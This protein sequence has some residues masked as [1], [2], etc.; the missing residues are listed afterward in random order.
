MRLISIGCALSF[1]VSFSLNAQWT[2]VDIGTTVDVNC[3]QYLNSSTIILGTNNDLIRS[4]D[5]G[6]TWVS[7]PILDI[8][9]NTLLHDV[10]NDV[11]FVNSTTGILVGIHL[12]ANEEVILRTTDGGVSWS[13]VNLFLGGAYPRYLNEVHFMN[14]STGVAVGT[15]GRILRTIDGGQTWSAV[16]SY[17]TRELHSVHFFS[18][19]NGIIVGD[20][21]ILTTTNAGSTWSLQNHPGKYL[22]SVRTLSSSL[23]YTCGNGIYKSTTNGASWTLMDDIDN[24]RDVHITNADSAY[25][26]YDGLLKTNNAGIYWGPQGSAPA[27]IYNDIDFLNTTSGYAVGENGLVVRTTTGG[28][29]LPQLDAGVQSIEY[30]DITV[31]DGVFPIRARVRNFG[32]AALTSATIHWSVDGVEQPAYP[33]T[34]VLTTQQL[35]EYIELGSIPIGIDP[36]NIVAWT[37]S[38]NGGVD[39]FTENDSATITEAS[40]RMHGTY[41]VGGV[42]PDFQSLTWFSSA[43]S[44]RGMCGHVEVLLRDG[45]YSGAFNPNPWVG[46]GSE[47]VLTIRSES[48]DN[49]AVI[50][51]HTSDLVRL[52]GVS[53]IRFEDITFSNT[54]GELACDLRSNTHHVEFVN[55]RFVGSATSI[56]QN[57]VIF[58]TTTPDHIRFIGCTFINGSTALSLPGSSFD[59]MN[60]LEVTGCTFTDQRYRAIS[61][62][63]ANALLIT[64]NTITCTYTDASVSGIHLENI[65]GASVIAGNQVFLDYSNRGIVILNC[66]YEN[67]QTVKVYNN[68]LRTGLEVLNSYRIHIVH[69]TVRGSLRIGS[70]NGAPQFGCTL[71][72]NIFYTR[73]VDS[74]GNPGESPLLRIVLPGP[75]TY[76]E[77]YDITS[78][79]E[80]IGRNVFFTGSRLFAAFESVSLE[81]DTFIAWKN[82]YTPDQGSVFCDPQFAE[83]NSFQIIPNSSNYQMA[84][85]GV[86]VDFAST[87]FNG[88]TRSSNP[89]PGAYEWDSPQVDAALFGL[90]ATTL[91]CE[92]TSELFVRMANY[93]QEPVT[94][95]V[96]ALELDGVQLENV[97]WNGTLIPGDSTAF[98]SLGSPGFSAGMHAFSCTL[99]SVNGSPDV[100]SPNNEIAV[101]LNA[102]GVSG[103]FTIGGASPDFPTIQAAINSIVSTGIC[104][105]VTFDIRPGT[106]QEQITMNV[107][108]GASPLNRITFQSENGDSSSV[109]IQF[110]GTGD[111]NGFVFKLNNADYVTFRRLS[112]RSQLADSHILH[113]AGSCNNIELDHCHLGVTTIVSDSKSAVYFSGSSWV[114]DFVA[115]H[116]RFEGKGSAVTDNSH[117]LSRHWNFEIYSCHLINQ[118]FSAIKLRNAYYARIYD[119][120]IETSLYSSNERIGIELFDGYESVVLHHNTILGGFSGAIS[121]GLNNSGIYTP[122]F[123]YN[124]LCNIQSQAGGRGI[125]CT[126]SYIHVVNNTVKMETTA[127]PCCNTA[128]SL[129]CQQ[130]TAVNNILVAV[131][132]GSAIRVN[133]SI[134]ALVDYNYYFSEASQPFYEDA[135]GGGGF[136]SLE[137]WQ[138]GTGVDLNSYFGMPQFV[139][140]T[141]AHLLYDP[142]AA[143]AGTDLY[144]DIVTTDIDY[145]PRMSPPDI[146]ADEFSNNAFQLDAG[147][148]EIVN[149]MPVCPGASPLEVVIENSGIMPINALT[150]A[151][152]LNGVEQPVFNWTGTLDPATE[153]TL[154]LGTVQYDVMSEYAIEVSIAAVN[155]SVD[156]NAFNNEEELGDIHTQL[157]GNV[158]VGGGYYYTQI[159]QVLDEIALYGVCGPITSNVFPG[160]YDGF[161]IGSELSLSEVNTLTIQSVNGDAESVQIVGSSNQ[162]AVITIESADFVSLERIGVNAALGDAIH[163]NGMTH[164]VAVRECVIA[165]DIVSIGGGDDALVCEYNTVDGALILSGDAD[166]PDTLTEVRGNTFTNGR[167]M[168]MHSEALELE[169][170]VLSGAVSGAPA[171]ELIACSQGAGISMNRIEGNYV[172]GLSLDVTGTPGARVKVHNNM[173]HVTGAEHALSFTGSSAFA[174]VVFNTLSTTGGQ[175]TAVLNG[176]NMQFVNNVVAADQGVLLSIEAV[177]AIASSNHNVYFGNGGVMAEVEGV[178]FADLVSFQAGNPFDASSQALDPQFSSATSFA[179][180]NPEMAGTAVPWPDV[181]NDIL[182]VVR[183]A[184]APTAGAFEQVAAEVTGDVDGDGEVSSTDLFT[185]LGNYGC[186]GECAGDLDGDGIV[187]VLDLIILI[188]QMD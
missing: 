90:S 177:S 21:V 58:N 77:E 84:D 62:K 60:G 27:G 51:Q 36:V 52:S 129:L 65:Q 5:G 169:S 23:A 46:G 174:D 122:S 140:P 54:A 39:Q 149:P 139:S 53:Y 7:L 16:T 95:A 148:V 93:G 18:T 31:C 128:M 138:N 26:A 105:P 94:Q 80:S 172:G 91:V 41:T 86:P 168:I 81:F 178:Q 151:W 75:I 132:T 159:Q 6:V 12:L 116:C 117:P 28:E 166:Q 59:Y 188:G 119:N 61:L 20:E 100:E 185:L 137:D 114:Y 3:V 160:T 152:Q 162:E 76:I 71:L 186:V 101:S 181:T 55:C 125:R 141:D 179:P 153:I 113:V 165:G 35:S 43:F 56:L 4:D 30:I 64:D 15:N 9:G 167:I 49:T 176:A 147:V 157:S 143:N 163:L 98:I 67:I 32:Q 34:G 156:E 171:I 89:D 123:V 135:L 115:H 121:I 83:A 134:M 180:V 127:T 11:H 145:E 104:G 170:N 144:A 111:A 25:I 124:N 85:I 78:L 42:N 17:T 146:G 108:P 73:G 68:T 164:H 19:S 14:Q 120:T 126:G 70:A 102:T 155:G 99:L 24:C 158:L 87:D 142:I 40:N 29:T 38:P 92:G 2:V 8:N 45:T 161:S 50:L 183:D 69:N 48:G 63:Y 107:V 97:I 173:V 22:K 96:I 74:E 112:M 109:I 150:I 118:R 182:G 131:G 72:N 187:G 57:L 130:C 88:N 33:W 37:T 133:V 136:D 13:I 103:T 154:V 79:F 106:Y 110:N 10:T 44:N 184:I 66:N 47:S 1:F 175:H 82:F